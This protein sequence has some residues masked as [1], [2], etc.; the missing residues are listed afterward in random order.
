MD[1]GIERHRSPTS[2]RGRWG[3]HQGDPG[4]VVERPGDL[5]ALLTNLEEGDILFI[6]EIHRLYLTWWKRFF[7]PPWKTTRSIY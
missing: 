4:P 6:D 1:A 3:E 2:F 5:A 7:T